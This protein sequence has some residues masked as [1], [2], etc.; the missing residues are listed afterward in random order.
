MTGKTSD[1]ARGLL[2]SVR[3]AVEA[4]PSEEEVRLSIAALDELISYL[5]TLRSQLASQPTASRR[6][7]VERALVILDSFLSG[8][9]GPMM[10]ASPKRPRSGHSDKAP[11]L[12]TTRLEL[13]AL[14]LDEIRARLQDQSR[15][16]TKLLRQLARDLGL[17]L[18]SRLPRGDLADAILKRGF[19][20]PRAYEGLR[21]DSRQ[22]TDVG[23]SKVEPDK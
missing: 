5:Q 16:S 18:D 19:A 21:G 15:Y 4:L 13:E 23:T 1:W 11:D 3:S 6:E 17:R 10:L 20:N 22:R 14:E 12:R 9:R 2:R 8:S 7:D